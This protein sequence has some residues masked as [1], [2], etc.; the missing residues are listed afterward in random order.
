MGQSSQFSHIKYPALILHILMKIVLSC[1]Q[2]ICQ[3]LLMIRSSLS[4]VFRII[5]SLKQCVKLNKKAPVL[6]L[7]WGKFAD[8]NIFFIEHLEWLLLNQ[9]SDIWQMCMCGC[10]FM[11]NVYVCVLFTSVITLLEIV[12][13]L[14]SDFKSTKLVLQIGCPSFYLISWRK[15]ALIQNPSSPIPKIFNR[16]GIAERQKICRCKCFNM[17]K[18]LKA[19]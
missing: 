7:F 9:N 2:K 18:Y 19:Y 16:H 10:S 5:D 8:A 13:T 17:G 1:N 6:E 11:T 3:K 14:S 15:S 12:K 4:P